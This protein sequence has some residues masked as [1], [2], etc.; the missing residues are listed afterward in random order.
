[1]TTLFRLGA[2]DDMV[3]R[4]KEMIVVMIER[5]DANTESWQ[6]QLTFFV[7]I[8]WFYENV[9]LL[10]LSLFWDCWLKYLISQQLF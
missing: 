9:P 1:M 2:F 5:Q 7:D 4:L 6:E 3:A 8:L 10:L